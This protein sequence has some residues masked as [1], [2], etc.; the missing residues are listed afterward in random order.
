MTPMAA[1][2]T[3]RTW[4]DRA[5]GIMRVEAA[6][7]T[8]KSLQ[9]MTRSPSW[10]HHASPYTVM[11]ARRRRRTIRPGSRLDPR[12]VPLPPAK[13]RSIGSDSRRLTSRGMPRKVSR[14]DKTGENSRPTNGENSTPA[15]TSGRASLEGDRAVLETAGGCQSADTPRIDVVGPGYIGHRLASREPLSSSIYIFDPSSLRVVRIQPFW[16]RPVRTRPYKSSFQSMKVGTCRS[17]L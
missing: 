12:A 7:P 6:A 3:R 1:S 2:G 5:V 11:Q 9:S 4:A 15:H 10:T 16:W 13:G 8:I 14:H 17:A